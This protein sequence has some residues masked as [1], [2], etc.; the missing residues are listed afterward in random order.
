M[1]D[2]LT[3]NRLPDRAPPSTEIG[4]IHWAK[5]HLFGSVTN[6]LLTLASLYALYVLV[7]PLINWGLISANFAGTDR[8]VCDANEHGACWTFIKVR[9]NQIMFG[10]YYGANPDQLWRPILAFFSLAG[11]IVPSVH[12][13]LQ[14]QGLAGGLH[15]HHLPV[16]R[17][18]AHTRS[19]AWPARR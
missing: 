9:F 13:S 15:P 12:G 3:H 14:L 6:T 11:L 18:C 5:I 16:H 17:L 8:S 10:L 7:P 4:P 2:L 19:L 1:S